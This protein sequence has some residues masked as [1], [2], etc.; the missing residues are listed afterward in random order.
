MTIR[1]EIIA[2]LDGV[3]ALGNRNYADKAPENEPK[4]HTRVLD[5]IAESPALKGDARTLARRRQ[6]QVDLWQ[7]AADDDGA[8]STT[9]QNV[10]DGASIPSALR[11]SVNS[12][13]RVYDPDF[14]LSH[15][16]IT[17]ETVR[18]RSAGYSWSQSIGSWNV[19]T[20]IW[21][22]A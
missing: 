2:L 10:L 13:N 20:A 17:L 22:D 16:V 9:V 19:Q 5:Q 3:V 14:E 18:L 1:S 21:Q 11:L 15:T 7:R 8:L 6:V 12:A 4:P